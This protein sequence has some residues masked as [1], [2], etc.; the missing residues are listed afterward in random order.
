MKTITKA[1]LIE[2]IQE[3]LGNW[4]FDACSHYGA[5]QKEALEYAAA[6][7]ETLCDTDPESGK[8]YYEIMGKDI[9]DSLSIYAEA[10][11]ANIHAQ[12]TKQQTC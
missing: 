5:E 8:E 6:H 4:D 12:R 1:E 2:C 9:W 3:A 10:T 11:G 7:P